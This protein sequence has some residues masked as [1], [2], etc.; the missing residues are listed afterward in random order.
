MYLFVGRLTLG[1]VVALEPF[2]DSGWIAPP[3]YQPEWLSNRECLAAYLAYAS[4]ANR[5]NLSKITLDD[6]SAMERN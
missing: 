6:F 5:I 4:F 1:D 3:L 2:I